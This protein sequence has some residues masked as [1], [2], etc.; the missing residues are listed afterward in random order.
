L[1]SAIVVTVCVL[2]AVM[3]WLF[4]YY[5]PRQRHKREFEQYVAQTRAEKLATY[6]QENASLSSGEID[7]VFLGDSLTDFYDVSYYYPQYR[8]LNRGIAGDTTTGLLGRLDTS[9]YAV[10]PKVAVMLIGVN[11][12]NTMMDDYEQLL[13]GFAQNL[14]NTHIV[15]LSLTCMTQQ[16]AEAVGNDNAASKNVLIRQ[17]ADK[18]GYTFVDIYTPLLD[19]NTGELA[20]DYTVDGGHLSDKGYRV[21]TDTVTPVLRSILGY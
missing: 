9:V 1:I 2:T 18:Y 8:V 11:N 16:W 21:L 5:L 7:V 13:I 20:L 4:A 17:L 3:A 12:I 15:L 14:P 10:Q 6:A 19:P